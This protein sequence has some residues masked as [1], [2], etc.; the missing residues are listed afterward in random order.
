VEVSVGLNTVAPAT[1]DNGVND[2][3]ALAGV[4][5]TKNNQFFF[6]WKAFHNMNYEQFGIYYRS[7]F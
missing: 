6:L 7:R 3:A 5:I 1:F 4:G 2:S